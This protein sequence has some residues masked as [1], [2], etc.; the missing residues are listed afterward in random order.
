VA[1][2]SD[3]AIT[4]IA[5]GKKAA[6]AIDKYLGGKGVLN[7]GEDIEIPKPS[8]EKEIIEHER[9]PMKFLE[10]QFRGN[11]FEEVCIGFHKL[12][13]IAESM[14]CLRCDRRF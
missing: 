14:R 13:A 5:D 4:A 6:S 8:D 3:V 7:T 10:P 9:F 12:N 1:R 2:G 11:N